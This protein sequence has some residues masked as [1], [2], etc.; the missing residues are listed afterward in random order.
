MTSDTPT[1]RKPRGLPRTT[2]T[3]PGKRISRGTLHEEVAVR[4]R[5]MILVDELRPGEI[6][7][8]LQLCEELG[9]SRTPMR[10]ALK[11]LASENLVELHP[12]Y[13]AVVAQPDAEDIMG[14]L[15]AIGAIEAVAAELACQQISA[16]EVADI[17][18]LH[19]RMLAYHDAGDRLN[20]FEMN[21]R[22]H[23]KIVAASRNR[24]LIDLHGKLN[25]RSR[26]IRY[27]SNSQRQWWEQ[28]IRE[29]QQMLEAL[30]ARDGGGLAG[31]MRAHMVGSWKD[32]KSTLDR[33]EDA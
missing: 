28:A 23:K 16:R 12:G 5:D 18:Q 11:V 20:Y 24:F 27:V 4:L 2:G 9:I 14:M 19:E 30:K 26:R 1:K 25:M 13:G 21:Q 32:V 6:I 7:P 22:I 10:E 15:Y 8:E 3:V 33:P 29:H 31:I 17:Q